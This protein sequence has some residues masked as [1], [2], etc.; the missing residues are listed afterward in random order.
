MDGSS[1]W[2]GDEN[3]SPDLK[4][5]K[6]T[7]VD[8]LFKKTLTQDSGWG[9]KLW[10]HMWT[11]EAAQTLKRCDRDLALSLYSEGNTTYFIK[12]QAGEYGMIHAM[13][14]MHARSSNN[15]KSE[16]KE[17]MTLMKNGYSKA[18]SEG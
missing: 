1:L 7:L 11:Q 15:I 10:S 13:W 8:F 3:A 18:S 2:E 9:D 6:D 5:K 17:K 4:W 16:R 14:R 12:I